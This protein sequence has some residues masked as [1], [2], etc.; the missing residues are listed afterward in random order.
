MDGLRARFLD[1][2]GP[3]RASPLEE[4]RAMAADEPGQRPDG[5]ESLI[6]GGRPAAALLFQFPQEPSD[7]FSGDILDAQRIDWPGNAPGR[8]REQQPQRVPITAL[9]IAR[10]IP[11]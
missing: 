11:L 3:D 2:D 8:V 4:F 6:A 9:R 7:D 5:G 1:G 10:Q